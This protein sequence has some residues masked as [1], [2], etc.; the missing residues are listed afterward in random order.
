MNITRLPRRRKSEKGGGGVWSKD[1]NCP[2]WEW[3]A[4]VGGGGGGGG[5]YD[6]KIQS[7]PK[8]E[9][10]ATQRREVGDGKGGEVWD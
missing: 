4:G 9:R 2:K 8:W 3:K 1:S 5:G 7:A 10:K 6:E